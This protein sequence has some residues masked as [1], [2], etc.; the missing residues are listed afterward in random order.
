MSESTCNR[1]DESKITR[2]N[3]TAK[4]LAEDLGLDNPLMESDQGPAPKEGDVGTV[5]SVNTSPKKGTRKTPVESGVIELAGD[6]GVKD[7]A[8]AGNWHRQVSFLAQE[9]I[10]VARDHGLDVGFGDFGENITTEGINMKG[11]PLGTILK[12]GTATVEISQ[13]GKVCHTRC[14]IYYLAGD[15]IFPRE[16]V[17]GWVVEPGEVRTGDQVRV[18]KL[19][20]GEVHRER[21]DKPL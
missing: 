14:A 3:E 12:V 6:F 7:D 19:G 10:Q 11:M 20:E 17:F 1:I 2:V 8:H 5:L 18:V 15:C 9:S 16:G 13:I 21:S 4:A